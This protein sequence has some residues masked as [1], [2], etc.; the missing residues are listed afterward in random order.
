MLS[1]QS[2]LQAQEAHEKFIRDKMKYKKYQKGVVWTLNE[3]KQDAL[4]YQTKKEWRES[5]F[6]AY[7]KACYNGWLAQ[8][9]GHMVTSKQRKKK[10]ELKYEEVLEVVKK[11]K[12]YKDFRENYERYYLWSLR[13][14]MTAQF[15][16]MFSKRKIT[17]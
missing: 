12:N 10:P 9:C 6:T 17:A 16:K 5:N 4:Q 13:H 7:N 14:K 2:L 3:C 8:C 15:K 11:A 1:M